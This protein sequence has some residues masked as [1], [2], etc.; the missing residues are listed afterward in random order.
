MQANLVPTDGS[1]IPGYGTRVTKT[2]D[3]TSD[4]DSLFTV[5]NKVMITLLTG[6]VTGDFPS[7][8]TLQL[9]LDTGEALCAATTVDTDAAGTMYLLTGDADDDLCGGDAITTR[10]ATSGGQHGPIVVGLASGTCTIQGDLDAA[11]ASGSVVWTL[12]Y[13]PLVA[14]AA[15]ATAG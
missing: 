3:L 10:I 13:Y 14:S 1:Y 11:E 6:E 9:K 15:V 2:Q 4:P 5:T 8:C 12:Y 7:A